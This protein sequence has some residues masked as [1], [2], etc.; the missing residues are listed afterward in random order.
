MN[1]KRIFKILLVVSSLLIIPSLAF[2]SSSAN[3]LYQ[4]TQEGGLWHYEFAV[5]NTSN[6]NEYLYGVWLNFDAFYTILEPMLPEGWTGPWG[7]ISLASFEETHTNTNE[8][9]PGNE[10]KGFGF[11]SNQKIPTILYTAYF[12]NHSGVVSSHSD[13]SV[14]TSTPVVPEPLS[15][16]LFVVGGVIVGTASYVKR[17]R[18]N[19]VS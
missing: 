12:T 4:E 2:A 14:L 9:A 13:T 16:I 11:F 15:A 19:T 6:N 1:P 7:K 17:R 8:I 3:V 18:I 10:L 5:S